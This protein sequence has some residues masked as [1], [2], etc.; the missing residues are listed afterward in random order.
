MFTIALTRSSSTSSSTK[1]PWLV[2]GV[3]SVKRRQYTSKLASSLPLRAFVFS[4]P[5]DP[6]QVVTARTFA[7]LPPPGAN[8]VQ[9][10]IRLASINPSDVNVLQG[11][12]PS[13]PRP[14]TDL[15]TP[16]PVFIPGNEGLGEVIAVG[17]AASSE[18]GSAA[19]KVGDRVVMG[20]PQAGDMVQHH[21]HQVRLRCACE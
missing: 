13:K 2:K 6:L 12:Y 4:E 8:E 10:R 5:G 7:P 17:S 3:N 16:Q 20:M 21:E 1:A 19:L 11:V 15:G 14:R 9:L 18:T